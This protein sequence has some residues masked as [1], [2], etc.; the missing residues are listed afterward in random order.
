MSQQLV[1]YQKKTKL[2]IGGLVMAAMAVGM[3]VMLWIGPNPDSIF[4]FYRSPLMVY[5]LGCVGLLL[6][7]WLL[8]FAMK[9]LGKPKPRVIISDDGLIVDGFTGRF[10][11]RWS[12]FTGYTI[13]NKSIFIILHKD[14]DTYIA[15]LPSGRPKQTAEALARRFGSP[16]I[17]ETSILE[18]EMSTVEKHLQ[19]HL[20]S[21]D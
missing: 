17:I 15:S 16:F 12:D 19:N 2:I 11:G 6:S 8:W 1:I 9:S 14:L 4:R 3:V 5:G 21:T 20:R 7:L 13:K 18:T 10:A